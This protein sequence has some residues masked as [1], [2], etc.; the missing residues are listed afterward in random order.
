MKSVKRYS[1]SFKI[2]VVEELEKGEVEEREARYRY[3]IFGS[4]TLREWRQRYGKGG[5]EK[6][7]LLRVTMKSEEYRIQELEKALADAKLDNMVMAAQLRS[8]QRH[9]PDLK[10]KLS[11]KELQKF[12]ENEAKLKTSRW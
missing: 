12:E 10:K 2:K 11:L 4:R 6:T 9:V 3:G 7:Q 5:E 1:E 8:Y